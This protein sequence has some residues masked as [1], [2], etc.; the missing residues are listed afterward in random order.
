MSDALQL[1]CKWSADTEVKLSGKSAA[2]DAAI[3]RWFLLEGA[4]GAEVP[5]VRATL[6]AGFKKITAACNS[7]QAIFS[8]RH[9]CAAPGTTASRKAAA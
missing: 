9:R 3:R 8:E 2:T 7:G 1:A 6:L 5:G 4:S